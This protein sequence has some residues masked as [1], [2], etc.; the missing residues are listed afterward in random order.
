MLLDGQFCW[1]NY[2]NKYRLQNQKLRTQ[3]VALFLYDFDANQTTH[4]NIHS[5]SERIHARNYTFAYPA[6]RFCPVSLQLRRRYSTMGLRAQFGENEPV[7]AR[8]FDAS[9]LGLYGRCSWNDINFERFWIAGHQVTW[10]A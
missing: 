5:S 1:F 4:E 10:S 8:V 3:L 6:L 2:G 7:E 9:A